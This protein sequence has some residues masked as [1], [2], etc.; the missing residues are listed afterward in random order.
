MA[1]GGHGWNSSFWASC[2]II[3]SLPIAGFAW[4]YRKTNKGK[5]Y[6]TIAVSIA[7]FADVLLLCFTYFE[8]FENAFSPFQYDINGE[9]GSVIFSWYL[10]W[11]LWQLITVTVFGF[12]VK[13][14]GI[15]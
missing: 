11:C 3:F 10:L 6:S 12:N 4:L 8:G 15:N 13:Q 2:L 9:F 5:K 1:G 7:L 14:S